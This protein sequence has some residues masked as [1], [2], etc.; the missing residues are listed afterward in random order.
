[1]KG[2]KDKNKKFHPINTIKSV[3]RKKRL[4]YTDEELIANAGVKIDRKK[5]V[6]LKKQLQSHENFLKE[7]FNTG[8][9][10]SNGWKVSR[11]PPIGDER[12]GSPM[13]SRSQ[14]QVEKGD[15]RIRMNAIDGRLGGGYR[16]TVDRNAPKEYD[17]F[18]IHV[19]KYDEALDKLHSFMRL[20]K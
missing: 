5:G 7:H 15:S 10:V 14:I 1:M 16:I 13:N 18:D 12:I 2:F 3:T 4:D 17:S 19:K 20:I 11:F 6:R 9:K 8:L